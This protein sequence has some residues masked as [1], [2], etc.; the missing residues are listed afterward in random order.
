MEGG[1]DVNTY[2]HERGIEAQNRAFRFNGG[3][4]HRFNETDIAVDRLAIPD[5]F[6]TW[7]IGTYR[8][9]YKMK[10]V[11]KTAPW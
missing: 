4:P 7:T 3:R 1:T 10:R 11:A 6:R 2:K 5:F 8:L 9:V